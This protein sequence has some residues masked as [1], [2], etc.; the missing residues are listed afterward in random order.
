MESRSRTNFLRKLL[1]LTDAHISTY[2]RCHQAGEPLSVRALYHH[3][4]RQVTHSGSS[5]LTICC[6]PAAAKA[7]I[8]PARMTPNGAITGRAA[9]MINIAAIMAMIQNA[10]S[11]S[12]KLGGLQG[13]NL[14]DRSSTRERYPTCPVVMPS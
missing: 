9:G 4:S 13:K 2:L 7:L 8:P 5:A 11:S 10:A 14:F 1:H 3:G 6:T 12:G